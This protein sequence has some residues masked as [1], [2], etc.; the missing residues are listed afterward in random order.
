MP[1]EEVFHVWRTVSNSEHA[2][3]PYRIWCSRIEGAPL[4]NV[5]HVGHFIGSA[6]TLKDAKVIALEH[7]KQD[8]THH[9]L[10]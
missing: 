5:Y 1:S 2:C 3:H 8:A 7:A 4:V 9:P 6:D 10:G